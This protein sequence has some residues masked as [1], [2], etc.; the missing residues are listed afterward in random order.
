MRILQVITSL[1][2]GGAEKLVAEMVPLFIQEGHQVDILLFSG[3]RTPLM[4][5]L[6]K[7]GVRVFKLSDATVSVY[8]PLLI[9]K[10]RRFI[11]KY[12]I[13]HTHNTACQFYVALSK[14]LKKTSAQLIT[15][16]HSTS[17]RR[18]SIRWFKSLDR[19]MYK[20][21]SNVIS[22]SHK[23]TE[24]L[25]DYIGDIPMTTI[26]NGINIAA[27]QKA[28]PACVKSDNVIIVIMVAGFRKEKDQDTLIRAISLLPDSY[29]LWLVGDGERRKYCEN[30]SGELGVS[31]RVSFLG[32]RTD[33]PQL[34]K[35]ADIVV[36]SSHYEGLSLSSIEG[37]SVGK[38]F[39]ASDVDGL[40]EI[41]EG[42]G[43]LFPHENAEALAKILIDLVEDRE[44]YQQI[45]YRCL[46]RAM[47]YDIHK[48]VEGYLAVYEKV[49]GRN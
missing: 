39:V 14:V 8:N 36:M 20:Q 45:S 48:T 25:S 40:H 32:I 9:F 27:F 15:T 28:V 10:L 21:Y 19:W 33:V 16:E 35:S 11:D 43:L 47:E 1:R 12:D 6:E 46:Q 34:L 31:S 42:A 4:E 44:Y 13:I 22:I 37:M 2:M 49:L 24:L 17:N 29:R 38:P 30:L 18:R 26:L 5:Q 7:Q 41:T 3:E 23:A